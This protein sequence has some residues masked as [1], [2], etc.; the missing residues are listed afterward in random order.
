MQY[1]QQCN[2]FDVVYILSSRSVSTCVCEWVGVS[3]F[4]A[5]VQRI[6]QS[7]FNTYLDRGF[8]QMPPSAPQA[9]TESI[10]SLNLLTITRTIL[11][12]LRLPFSWKCKWDT[13]GFLSEL[14][15]ASFSMANLAFK[16]RAKLRR[17]TRGQ[18]ISWFVLNECVRFDSMSCQ[19]YDF[20]KIVIIFFWLK[21]SDTSWKCK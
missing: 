5:A 21:V 13:F 17:R 2:R 20:S 11:K 8:K 14:K 6:F 1:V 19:W 4:N 7:K 18:K 3:V 15:L 16:C 12:Y 9:E 10:C